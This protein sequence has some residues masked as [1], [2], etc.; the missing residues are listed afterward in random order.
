MYP[1]FLFGPD[2]CILFLLVLIC[3]SLF[4]INHDLCILL[5]LFLICLYLFLN[6]PDL[7]VPGVLSTEYVWIGGAYVLG[8]WQWSDG[9]PISGGYMNGMS[10]LPTPSFG[11]ECLAMHPSLGQWSPQV[12]GVLTYTVCEAVP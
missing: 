3:V 9:S 8:Q 7:M 2:L 10:S 6:D 11:M 5:L 12:C 4:V 1:C